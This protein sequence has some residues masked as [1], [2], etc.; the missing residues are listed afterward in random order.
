MSSDPPRTEA[1]RAADTLLARKDEIAETVTESVYAARPD[2]LA[3][4]GAAGRAKCVQDMR[5]TVEHLA[6]AVAL[7]EPALFTRYVAWLVDLLAAR[8]IPA[9]D[10]RTSLQAM[11]AALATCLAREE[12]EAAAHSVRAA[13]ATLSDKRAR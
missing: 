13:L 8:A 3:R 12:S 1:A 7:G 2:L 11:E 10:V 4:Y 9:D 6:P 5:Y